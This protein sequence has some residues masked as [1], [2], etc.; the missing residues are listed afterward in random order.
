[1]RR[2]LFG[3]IGL[4]G[5]LVVALPG[6]AA[7]KA[8]TTRIVGHVSA[9]T[10]IK[11]ATLR[12]YGPTG[13]RLK[14]LP[15]RSVARTTGDGFFDIVVAGRPKKVRLVATGVK[16]RQEHVQGTLDL[17]VVRPSIA[18]TVYVNPVTTVIAEVHERHPR[19]SL[20]HATGEARRLLHLTPHDAIG[21]ELLT[22]TPHFNGHAFMAAARK[23]GGLADYIDHIIDDN[24]PV[25][26]RAQATAALPFGLDKYKP[27]LESA[28]ASLQA[29]YQI[30]QAAYKFY[31]WASG[32]PDDTQKILNA[33][34]KLSEKLDKIQK[35]LDT[36]HD[37]LTNGLIQMKQAIDESTFNN[38]VAP[39]QE[40]AGEV[41][42]TQGY[43]QD[44][45]DNRKAGEGDPR[46]F[47]KEL[48][49]VRKA[50]I[51]ENVNDIIKKF[52]G[53]GNIF[54]GA[55]LKDGLANPAYYYAGQNLLS[56]SQFFMTSAGSAQLDSFAKFVMSY[57]ALAFNLILQWENSLGAGDH[58]A[59]STTLKNAIKQYLGFTVDEAK[60]W[61]D[62]NHLV[63]TPSI[64]PSGDL[65][66]EITYLQT[67]RQIP[68]NA[69]VQADDLGHTQGPMWSTDLG[70]I[71]LGRNISARPGNPGVVCAPWY[72]G[73]LPLEGK[74]A[75]EYMAKGWTDGQ[76]QLQAAKAKLGDTIT[77]WTIATADQTQALLTRAKTL[78]ASD[79][80]SILGLK[81][82][83]WYPPEYTPLTS[84]YYVNNQEAAHAGY[85]DVNRD[86]HCSWLATW[87]DQVTVTTF[88]VD[89]AKAFKGSCRFGVGK[90]LGGTC[91]TLRVLYR[92][93]TKPA[94]GETYW[95]SY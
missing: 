56:H 74:S 44:L 54:R 69:V 21:R 75:C 15:K 10:P 68:P 1:M 89:P 83:L 5:L 79:K 90:H 95:P 86:A 39:L 92:H 29:G 88:S 63:E 31:Q 58:P 51:R 37:D 91:P 7:A 38:A 27:M 35:S 32:E 41:A 59:P 18:K 23:H 13:H 26:F 25:S 87:I 93:D 47:S 16:V 6:V 77:D 73:A 42:A 61:L 9:G 94:A 53:V 30:G 78:S 33:I 2:R 81:S 70:G 28:K 48:Y 19:R 17:F 65:H 4:I 8:R 24:A 76:A 20:A 12:V 45:I 64:P 34:N 67:I 40:L 60:E 14:I 22:N 52:Q 49:D 36:I 72:D 85:C 71:E 57:Q 66:D 11:G 55:I 82:D 80:D 46:D 50:D 43:F 84:T 3:A 62:A